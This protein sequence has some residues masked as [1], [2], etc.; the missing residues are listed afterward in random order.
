MNN[1]K[2]LGSQDNTKACHIVTSTYPSI[3]SLWMCGN[4]PPYKLL[5]KKFLHDHYICNSKSNSAKPGFMGRGFTFGEESG[6][7]FNAALC[8]IQASERY[9]ESL[10]LVLKDKRSWF[11]QGERLAVQLPLDRVRLL[12]GSRTLGWHLAVV[13]RKSAHGRNIFT[14]PPKDGRLFECF[15]T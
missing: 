5:S 3:I 13:S 12:S 2:K 9:I 6:S 7:G 14:C 1:G 11:L 15:C 4:R 8:K 10:P